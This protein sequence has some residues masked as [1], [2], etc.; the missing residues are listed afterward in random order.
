MAIYASNATIGPES[1]CLISLVF[2]TILLPDRNHPSPT[3]LECQQSIADAKAAVVSEQARR[4]MV[5]F[6]RHP[7][8]TKERSTPNH[9]V[10]CYQGL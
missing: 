9:S 4:L 5:F 1:L 3:Q 6:F 8:G 7:E 2:G 10:I